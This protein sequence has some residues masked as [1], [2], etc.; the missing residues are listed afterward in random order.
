MRIALSNSANAPVLGMEDYSLAKYESTCSIATNSDLGQAGELLV[1]AD[2]LKRG[3]P[4][5]K[6][7]NINGPHDLHAK[8]GGAWR[9]IQVKVC[10]RHRKT[11]KL[12]FNRSWH[13]IESD[14]V[15]LVFPIT[16]QIEYRPRPG[17]ELPAEFEAFV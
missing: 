7:L 13:D 17:T 2:L 5:T 6:P 16:G 1:A 4:S 9:T 8:A 11:G 15:A 14:I 10:L 12:V 3:L